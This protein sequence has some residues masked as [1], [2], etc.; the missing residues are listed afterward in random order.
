M[1]TKK[2]G[3]IAR[4]GARYGAVVKEKV[5]A[6]EIKQRQKQKCPFCKKLSTKRLAKGL[7]LCRACK[8]KFASHSY[9]I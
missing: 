8:K 1:K 6:V 4:F 5:R 2:S 3:P 9:Y 7:W